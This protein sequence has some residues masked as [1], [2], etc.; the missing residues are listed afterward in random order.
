M[1]V[2]RPF[3]PDPAADP[4]AYEYVPCP[5]CGLSHLVNKSSGKLVGESSEVSARTAAV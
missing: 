2:A 4:A 1:N 3:A 5:A